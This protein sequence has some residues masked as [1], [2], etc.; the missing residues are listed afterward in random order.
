MSSIQERRD[1]L[2]DG[3]SAPPAANRTLR[4]VLL[5]VIAVMLLAIAGA[6]GYL[7]RGD[8]DGSG[9]RTTPGDASIEAGFARD[10]IT[11]H[12]QAVQMAIIAEHGTADPSVR[13]LA[14]DIET[15]QT[16]QQGQMNGWLDAWGLTRQT[17]QPMMEWMDGAH[18]TD[19]HDAGG[20]SANADH[21]EADDP[22]GA[23]TALMPGMA[24][25]A[26]MTR[27][28]QSTGEDQDVLFLQLMLRHHQAGVEMAQAGADLADEPYV[29]ALAEKMVTVQ[30][31]EVVQMEQM[32][33]AREAQPLPR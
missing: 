16:F 33:R 11:H 13:A 27:L 26:E 30:A 29:C 2:R 3:T 28:Q 9:A 4:L 8:S 10:M 1:A 7:L 25:P 12:E 19:G 20:H 6:V 18:G 14:F 24:T 15:S 17:S 31:R 21:A 23:N 22:T 32:L 5:G